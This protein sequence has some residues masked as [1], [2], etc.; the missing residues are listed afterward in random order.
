MS[1]HFE[2]M[3]SG[4]SYTF[5]QSPPF[6]SSRNVSAEETGPD[7]PRVGELLAV[8][9]MGGGIRAGGIQ[10]QGD[11][12]VENCG[13]LPWSGRSSPLQTEYWLGLNP[14]ISRFLFCGLAWR[15]KCVLPRGNV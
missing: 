15:A 8:R 10:K 4:I 12:Q 13:D 7:V 11:S 14:Q 2:Q 6:H 5:F 1:I 9:Q 3:D